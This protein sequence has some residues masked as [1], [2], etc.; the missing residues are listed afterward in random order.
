VC[1]LIFVDGAVQYG[2]RE[3][4]IARGKGGV[5]TAFVCETYL[6]PLRL[7][8]FLTSRIRAQC[9][10]AVLAYIKLWLREH[11]GPIS[12]KNTFLAAPGRSFDLKGGNNLITSIS[13]KN[14]G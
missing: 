6:E 2:A 13:K 8:N 3:L 7:N 14:N 4:E 5:R 10:S 11:T 12:N 1:V 9:T